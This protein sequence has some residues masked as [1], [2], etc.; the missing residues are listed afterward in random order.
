MIICFKNIEKSL[1]NKIYLIFIDKQIKKQIMANVTVVPVRADIYNL[2][3][4][5]TDAVYNGLPFQ[6]AMLAAGYKFVPVVSNSFVPNGN[7]P[8]ADRPDKIDFQAFNLSWDVWSS[9]V[10]YVFAYVKGGLNDL[11]SQFLLVSFVGYA[12][13]KTDYYSNFWNATNRGAGN[14]VGFRFGTTAPAIGATDI[15][16]G[17][18]VTGA[19]TEIANF[20]TAFN[21]KAVTATI[22]N[23]A[24]VGIASANAIISAGIATFTFDILGPLTPGDYY[25]LSYGFTNGDA[26]FS[27]AENTFLA[28]NISAKTLGWNNNTI[29]G[30]SIVSLVAA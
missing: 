18:I 9:I 8:C 1:I 16:A 11:W 23:K 3:A 21:G 10:N 7:N 6:S 25:N 17:T 14:F 27:T 12:G 15:W 2:I 13:L 28:A 22:Y 26:L 20:G 5:K 29:V 4:S 30:G 24:G 19:R